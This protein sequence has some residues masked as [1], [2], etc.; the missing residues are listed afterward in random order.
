MKKKN[1]I[2]IFFGVFLSIIYSI[3]LI[4]IIVLFFASNF[5][6]GNLYTDILKNID[7]NT[8]KLS[9][10]D[11]RLTSTFGKDVTLEEAFVN[12]LNEAGIESTVAKEIIN[13]PEIKE[14]VGDFVGDAINYSINKEKLPEITENDIDIILDT[15]YVES[16][17]SKEIE[18]EE[19]M[20][21]VD[22]I[23]KNTK[24]YLMEGFNYVN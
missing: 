4:I 15:V 12:V 10:I 17:G 18:K 23:N 14:V 2:G 16:I 19:I 11:P 24:D 3:G 6:K 22:D 7:L 13:N 1:K 5:T 21:Y 8:I 20:E 9:S